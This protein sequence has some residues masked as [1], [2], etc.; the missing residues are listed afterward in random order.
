[1]MASKKEDRA[2]LKKFGKMISRWFSKKMDETVNQRNEELA[3]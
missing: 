3:K 2:A 1:M